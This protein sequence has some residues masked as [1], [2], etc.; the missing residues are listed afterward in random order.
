MTE[1]EFEQKFHHNFKRTTSFF[2]G[3]ALAFVDAFIVL[4][5]I[6]IGFFII[7]LISPPSINFRSFIEYSSYLP[8]I[9]VVF[10]AANLYPGILI[11]PQQEVKR[12][13]LS[14]FFA[15]MG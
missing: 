6:G 1:A 12:F 8:F 14:T 7:N 11:A 4:L 15:F 3:L 13:S 5:C 2:S 9:L 10:Y